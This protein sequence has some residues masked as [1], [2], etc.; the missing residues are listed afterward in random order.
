LAHVGE[1]NDSTCLTSLEQDLNNRFR[2]VFDSEGTGNIFGTFQNYANIA[3][4]DLFCYGP[5]GTFPGLL[6]IFIPF[7]IAYLVGMYFK[8]KN[9]PFI[10]MHDVTR[11]LE[12][13]FSTATFQLGNRLNE[14]ISAELA[15]GAVADSMK[16]TPTG[17][18]FSVIDKNIKFNGMS[19]EKAIFDDEK[20]AISSY[21]SELITSSMKIFI[22]AVEKGPDIA[23]KTLIDLSRYLTEMHMAKERMKDLLSESISSMKGQAKFLAPIIA[24]VVVSIVS[25]VSLIMG[26]LSQSIDD[27]S[28]STGSDS[29]NSFALGNGMPTFLFQ[30][31]VGLYL[32]CLIVILVLVVNQLDSTGDKIHV[33]YELGKTVIGAISKYAIVVGAGILLFSFVGGQVLSSL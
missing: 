5:Y 30:T 19:I 27:L 29:L 7:G 24:A 33:Q 1:R 28:S 12:R 14:G 18:F 25:L 13:Q 22:R 4:A 8:L 31:S 23:A 11:N 32:V 9:E 17:D 3:S 21:P 26:K 16:G 15:F 10:H 6:S 20:G 2:A